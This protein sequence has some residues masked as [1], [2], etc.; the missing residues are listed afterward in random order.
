[1]I[2]IYIIIAF[3]FIMSNGIL[4]DNYQKSINYSF[5]MITDNESYIEENSEEEGPKYKDIKSRIYNA[6]MNM[7]FKG[8]YEIGLNYFYNNSIHNS[9]DLPFKG[10]YGNVNFSYYLKD[11]K[12][13]PINFIFGIG[14][15]YKEN[16]N[17]SSYSF[18]FF[19]EFN[20]GEYPFIPVFKYLSTNAIYDI[21]SINYSKTF[22]TLSI[23]FIVKLVVDSE[24]NTPVRDIIWFCPSIISKNN[25]Q[26]IGF[27]FGLYHPIK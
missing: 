21:E 26:Y 8:K 24:D 6:N 22:N 2:L 15:V 18:G 17:S 16:Y 25:D 14:G 13:V 1:M 5:G 12:K 20:L 4:S 19:K 27:S 23:D 9:Y 11:M 3:S 10:E 7:V